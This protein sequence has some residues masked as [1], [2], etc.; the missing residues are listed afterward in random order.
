MEA[1]SS[2]SK[3]RVEQEPTDEVLVERVKAGDKA[4]FGILV[5]RYERR[6]LRQAFSRL[7]NEQEAL[8]VCQ[9]AFVKAY[10]NIDQFQGNSG[11]Y[12]WLYRIV[13]NRCI[14]ITRRAGRGPTIDIDDLRDSP[15]DDSGRLASKFAEPEAAYR[16]QE[17][18]DEYSRALE[19]L[20]EKHREIFQ[21]YHDDGMSYQDIADHLDIKI[22]TVMSR[23]HH[24]RHNLQAALRR[25]FT[26]K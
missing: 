6:V 11:F 24:A 23:L 5:Q 13:H 19:G 26:R 14:D 22:G 2:A 16:S 20:S 17:F 4:A 8:D 9:D 12:T 18:W 21:L 10:R 7:R 25:Y 15:S 1:P 3:A